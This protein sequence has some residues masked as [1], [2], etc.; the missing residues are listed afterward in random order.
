MGRSV[1][2]FS[3]CDEEA[4]WKRLDR[5]R[6]IAPKT[7]T[8][9]GGNGAQMLTIAYL[10]NRRDC[11]VDWFFSSLARLVQ[12]EQPDLKFQLV[13]IDFYA[14]EGGRSEEF[15]AKF[16]RTRLSE[17][18]SLI[19]KPPKPCVWSGP[20]RLTKVSWFSVS[21][22]RNTAL[23]YAPDGWI[24]YVDDLSV[25]MPGW[26]RE[27]QHSMDNGYVSLGAYLKCNDVVVEDGRAITYRLH[28]KDTRWDNAS[29]DRHS[30]GGDWMYGCSLVAP[31]QAFLD[32][33]GWGECLCDGLGFEDVCTGIVLG[34][35]NK[36]AFRYNR[37]MLTLESEE[38]HHK[39]PAFRKEDWHWE[40][41]RCVVG[42]NGG[43]DKSH[44]ALNQARSTSRFEQYFGDGFSNIS[45][46]RQH[47]LN[48]GKFPI[49]GIPE[50]DWYSRIALKDL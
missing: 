26:L 35:T 24:A 15:A 14:E 46:L 39:E 10:T 16:L 49:R 22:V 4:H 31:V 36:Y 29:S 38:D 12:E 42:G 30:C 43:D 33:N 45:E 9:S 25:L 5:F 3:N 50:H 13:V 27:V 21:N 23:C 11:K 20:H 7:T 47:I 41:S 1:E 28:Q 2:H 40:G 32:I 34:N 44:S 18:C 48:G 8:K 19:H 6:V 17:N 37:N